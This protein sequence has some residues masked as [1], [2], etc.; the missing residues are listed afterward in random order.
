MK[1]ALVHDYLNQMGGAE[2]VVETLHEL[3]PEAP[4][5]TS[6]YLPEN[7][8]DSFRRMNIKTSFMQKLPFLDKHFKKYLLL[9]PY[10][11]RQFKLDDYELVLSSSSGWAKG[12]NVS[13][14]TCHICYCYTPMRWV[15]NYQDYIARENFGWLTKKTLP[16]AI[17]W[18]RRWDLATNFRVDHFVAISQCVAQRIKKYYHREATVIYPPVNTSLYQPAGQVEDFY[19]V[20]SRLNTYKKIDLVVETFNELGLHLKIIGTGPYQKILQNMAKT[21]IEFLGRVSDQKLADYYARC[22]ALIFPGEEDFGIAPLEAQA[23]GRPVIAYAGGGAIETVVE[24]KTGIFFRE[25]TAEAL[26][27]TIHSFE[28]MNFNPL[29]IRKHAQKFDREVFKSKLTAFI[30]E[31]YEE[32]CERKK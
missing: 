22:K 6:I 23:A 4:L 3:F 25:Q 1:I 12:V 2:R 8:P 16:L 30:K 18:L 7:M 10:A 17:N 21:N 31:K 11:F 13:P 19:L 27:R 5:Y 28:K 14:K 24:G 20:V 29:E 26:N 9:Y 15:W 32:H